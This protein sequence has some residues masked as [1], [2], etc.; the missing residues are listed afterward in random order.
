MN[1]E[2]LIKKWLDH[3]LTPAELEEF[4]S[5]E[6]YNELVKIQD[7]VEGYK[8]P[9]FNKDKIWIGLQK[10]VLQK[11]AR[12]VKW[13]RT[14]SSVAAVLLISFGLLFF[15]GILNHSYQTGAS[16]LISFQLPD[17]SKVDLNANS[18]IE[19]SK[20]NWTSKRLIKLDGEAYFKVTPG[21]SFKVKTASG[22][23]T[24]LGT[25]FNVLQ[26]PG[27]F[28][29]V[30]YEGS[31]S[32]SSTNHQIIL[33]PGEGF[34]MLGENVSQL[35]TQDLS[36]SWLNNESS[37]DSLP[38]HLVIDELERQYNIVIRSEDVDTNQKYTG[39]FTHDN[40]NLAL[41]SVLTPFNLS[42]EI[43]N[44]EIVLSGE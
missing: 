29:V 17:D 41:K 19:H 22:E 23:V 2:L 11:S 31:V 24:V 3:D 25:E 40:L 39:S 5:L 16:E 34:R 15:S 26:R 8:A 37:F 4:K 12:P 14:I 36:P 9:V 13:L 32:V 44:E 10:D 1:K 7:I 21:E 38:L 30:C 33:K 20:F 6:D 35:R 43:I 28:E 18:N 27:I 42:F